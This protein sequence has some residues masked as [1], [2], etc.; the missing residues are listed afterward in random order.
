M[1]FKVQM[2]KP[3]LIY[4]LNIDLILLIVLFPISRQ[5]HILNLSILNLLIYEILNREQAVTSVKKH[6]TIV[7]LNLWIGILR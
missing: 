6:A 7:H 1:M 4:S 5:D 2:T 3:Y